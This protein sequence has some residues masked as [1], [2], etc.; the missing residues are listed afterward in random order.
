MSLTFSC[1]K[2][3]F[4]A[5]IQRKIEA[6]NFNTGIG[7]STI[8]NPDSGNGIVLFLPTRYLMLKLFTRGNAV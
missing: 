6:F 1:V 2:T 3:E 8:P 4:V 5:F 7:G